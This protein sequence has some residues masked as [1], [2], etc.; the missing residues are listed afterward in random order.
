MRFEA[1]EKLRMPVL[2]HMSPKEGFNYGV[3]D[4]PGTISAEL[5]ILKTVS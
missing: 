4:H 5:L 2:F 1:A 3:A